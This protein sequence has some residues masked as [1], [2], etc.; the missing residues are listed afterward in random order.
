MR[1]RPAHTSDST[2]VRRACLPF[3]DCSSYSL[4]LHL[5]I[6][7]PTRMR[8][9]AS[10]THLHLE[11]LSFEGTDASASGGVVGRLGD[12]TVLEALNTPLLRCVMDDPHCRSVGYILS[13]LSA[14]KVHRT[15]HRVTTPLD[16]GDWQIL[17]LYQVRATSRLW[18]ARQVKFCSR[19]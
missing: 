6:H 18:C 15:L 19:V 10:M 3:F 4:L 14:S 11:M 8:D 2:S 16:P 17:L 13:S 5:R 12:R 7:L 9:V 1:R